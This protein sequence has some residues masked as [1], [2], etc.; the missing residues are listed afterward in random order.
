[1]RLIAYL[2]LRNFFDMYTAS[3]AN[4]NHTVTCHLKVSDSRVHQ[5]SVFRVLSGV[6]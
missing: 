1:V 5:S 2:N 4:L 6:G 3:A